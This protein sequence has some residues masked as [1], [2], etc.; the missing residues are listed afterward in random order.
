MSESLPD[1]S[2]LD[3]TLSTLLSLAQS[4]RIPVRSV[5]ASIFLTV[6]SFIFALIPA[7]SPVGGE[8]SNWPQFRGPDANPV[9]S[10]E[11]LPER[12][13]KT[14]NVDWFVEIPG[15]GWSSPIVTAGKVFVTTATTDGKSKSPQ[16]GTEFSNQSGSSVAPNTAQP[17]PFSIFDL[18]S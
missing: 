9:G 15:R 5:V 8:G 18:A 16:I 12:W 6:A 2:K 1:L 7:A 3:G 13:S 17:A 11:R 14:E 4:M 10:H